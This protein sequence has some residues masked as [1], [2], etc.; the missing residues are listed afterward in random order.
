MHTVAAAWRRLAYHTAADQNQD[1]AEE[2]AWTTAFEKLLKSVVRGQFTPTVARAQHVAEPMALTDST[3][4]PP[5][6]HGDHKEDKELE[7]R[8]VEGVD[9]ADTDNIKKD[10]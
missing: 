5:Y 1:V 7:S 2:H 3:S 6:D 9:V 10:D 4:Q 8:Q